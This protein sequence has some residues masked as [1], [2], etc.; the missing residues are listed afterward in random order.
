MMTLTA[1]VKLNPTQDQHESLYDTMLRVNSACNWVSDVAWETKIFSQYSLHHEVYYDVRATFDLSAQLAV[2]CVAKVAHAY[3]LDEKARRLFRE[4]G[5]IAYDQR[6]LSWNLDSQQVSIL[7]IAGR[8]RIPFACHARAFEL[9]HGKRGQS[10]LCFI[11]GIF[12]LFCSC[13]VETPETSDV[14][15]FLGVDMGIVNIAADSDGTIYSGSHVNNLRERNE[16]IKARLQSK[17]T[18]SAKRLLKKRR[19]KESR[20][21]KDVNHVISKRV[22]ERAKG[23]GR[24]I[25]I[26]ELSGIRERTTV[27][28]GQRRRH[29][30][31]SFYDLRQKIEY[32]A[33]LAGIPVT[34]VDPR[35]T[36]QTCPVC[37]C[38]DKANRRTQ[39]NFSCTSCGFSAHADTVA[40]RNIAGRAVVNQ[41]HGS[42]VQSPD[43]QSGLSPSSRAKL[44]ALAGSS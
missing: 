32:K 30:S 20:F 19:K 7:T 29:H 25:A 24:G 26:E 8:E 2:R 13:E 4:N 1:K 41:P 44:P 42:E 5:A 33:K 12:Y 39:S 36:S 22:V 6:C 35:Y 10:D 18:K 23:T 14:T 43:L 17:G 34:V 28:K 31:W 16:K 38:V 3:K 11:D 37:G 21:A 15:E 9:L 40:A 27:R